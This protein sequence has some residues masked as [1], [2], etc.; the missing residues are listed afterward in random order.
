MTGWVYFT[1]NCVLIHH[2]GER[3]ACLESDQGLLKA[4]ALF[5]SLWKRNTVPIT[6][7]NT[8]QTCYVNVTVL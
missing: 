1:V 3:S 8:V 7:V 6:T 4:L 2:K 5:P